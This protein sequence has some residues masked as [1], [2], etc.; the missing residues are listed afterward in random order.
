MPEPGTDLEKL[1]RITGSAEEVCSAGWGVG[2]GYAVRKAA[3][4]CSGFYLWEDWLA[5]V[6]L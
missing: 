6:K 4:Q 3:L 1:A 2:W 5:S